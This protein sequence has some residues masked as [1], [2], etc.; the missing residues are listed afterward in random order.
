MNKKIGFIGSGNMARAMIKGLVTSN[1]INK[2]NIY[3]SNVNEKSLKE[4]NYLFEVNTSTSNET[5][6]RECDIIFLC[7]KPN[8]YEYIC[9]SIDNAIDSSKIIISIAPGQ[10]IEKVSGYFTKDIKVFS[11]MPNTPAKVLQGMSAVC[12]P[13]SATNEETDFVLS[14]FRC[15]GDAEL[16]DES[17]MNAVIATS[18]SS[19]AFIYILIEAMADASVSMGMPRDKAI[20]FVANAVL[21]SAKMVLEDDDHVAKLKDNVCSPGGTTIKGVLK[22]EETGFRQ[23]IQQAMQEVYNKANQM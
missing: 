21:G 7:T 10:N 1:K 16:I 9:K 5:I 23:S 14:L 4:I 19:P 13:V 20:K 18:G 3:V 12:A 15:F 2:N 11:S 6:A 22:L 17:L 8:K